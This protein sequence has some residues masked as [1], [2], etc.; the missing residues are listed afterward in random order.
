MISQMSEEKVT[1]SHREPI[2]DNL[3]CHKGES[4]T[5]KHFKSIQERGR[6]RGRERERET[7]EKTVS[8]SPEVW[9]SNV[10]NVEFLLP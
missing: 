5:F 2:R 9:G 7:A 8:L 1:C 3:V 10:L 4:S 6:G